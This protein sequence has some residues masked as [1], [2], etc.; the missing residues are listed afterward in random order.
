[1]SRLDRAAE[2]RR[3]AGARLG[4]MQAVRRPRAFDRG[5]AAGS[6][7]SA[8]S[9]AFCADVDTVAAYATGQRGVNCV[10]AAATPGATHRRG[11]IM[12][13]SEIPVPQTGF[14][15]THFLTVKDQAKSREFYVGVLGGKIIREE[16][17]CYIKLANSWIVLNS[18]GGP[19]PDKPDVWLAPPR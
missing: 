12:S 9:R 15:V 7:L 14:F 11:M 16:N 17:P 4:R 8:R 5:G 3:H 19:T 18:G 1:G 13:P 2:E 10:H 6:S